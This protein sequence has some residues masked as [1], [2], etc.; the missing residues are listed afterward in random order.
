MLFEKRFITIIEEDA[1]GTGAG[2]PKLKP[3]QRLGSRGLDRKNL[4][5][6]PNYARGRGD[7]ND[8]V[9][10]MRH[11]K[12]AKQILSPSDVAYIKN[13]YNIQDIGSGKKLGTTGGVITLDPITSRYI[14]TTS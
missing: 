11:G 8:K 14:L 7:L 1:F 3:Y 6:V 10:A 4:R 13:R 9:E 5:Q 2:L 12:I